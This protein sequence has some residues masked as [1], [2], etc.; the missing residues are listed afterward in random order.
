MLFQSLNALPK[1]T[2][3]ER[4][5]PPSLDDLKNGAIDTLGSLAKGINISSPK[6]A[7]ITIH[8]TVS[9]TVETA[10]ALV[11]ILLDP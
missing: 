3:L 10:N 9:G 11:S 8:D 7:V 5:S 4:A 1:H 6:T 2:R